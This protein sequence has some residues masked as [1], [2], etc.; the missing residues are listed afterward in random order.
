VSVPFVFLL[1]LLV[2]AGSAS[3]TSPL[4]GSS[5]MTSLALAPVL[6]PIPALLALV[7]LRRI[8]LR[9]GGG[10]IDRAHPRWWLLASAAASPTTVF[11]VAVPLGW[12]EFAGRIAGDS[13]LAQV[14]YLGLPLLVLELPRL[15]LS[16]IGWLWLEAEPRSLPPG[17]YR[18]QLPRVAE[19]WPILRLRLGWP[20]MLPLPTLVIGLCLDLLRSHRELHELFL[21][22]AIGSTLG[23][24][25]ALLLVAFLL[26][27]AFRLAFGVVST[28]PEPVGTELRKAAAKLGFAPHRV[29]MLPTGERALNAMMV[30]PLPFGRILCLTDGLL[31]ALG[32]IPLTGVVAHEVG[33]ARMG[34]PALLL[35]L[36]AVV[37]LLLLGPAMPLLDPSH[38]DAM[39]ISMLVAM[40]SVTC[41]STLRWLAHRF[42]HEADIASVRAFGAGPCSQALL[43]VSTAA[44]PMHNSW[45]GRWSSLHPDERQRCRVMWQYEN[46]PRFRQRFDQLGQRLR[47]GVGML[48]LGA[49]ATA[50]WSW[51]RDW[52]YERVVWRLNAGDVAGAVQFA[53]E[54]PEPVDPRW[55]RSWR[56]VRDHLQVAASIAG[57]ATDWDTAVRSYAQHAW[58]RGLEVLLSQGP[59]AARPW[60]AL[61]V[62]AEP[63]DLTKRL[64]FEYCRAADEQLPE[65]MEQATEILIRRGVPAELASVFQR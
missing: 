20:L 6:L 45:W 44:L 33:H 8:R 9:L 62:E 5:T 55:Q 10:A 38:H 7:G 41:W 64:V 61:A 42:E 34:H 13:Y 37:P 27:F 57:N 43:D 50:A 15:M 11:L 60:L 26:P 58:P 49:L 40:G 18:V 47:M 63:R 28:L 46:D 24:A 14:I 1:G 4:P 3:L 59:A 54:L 30:G 22:T 51:H 25:A 52:P 48:L 23:M 36:T 53:A 21:S 39:V 16:S 19:L 56:S 29:V 35:L 2:L 12:I 17:V 31:S 65:R 32:T